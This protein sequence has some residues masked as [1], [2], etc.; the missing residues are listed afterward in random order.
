ML[1][2]HFSTIMKKAITEASKLTLGL[3]FAFFL[4]SFLPRAQ[5][6]QEIA[7]ASP[8]PAATL[9]G[10]TV[11][12]RFLNLAPSSYTHRHDS[13][14]AG[15]GIA[16]ELHALAKA[17]SLP[18]K[19]TF[20]DAVEAL[21][22]P[23]AAKALLHGAD[24]LVLGGSTWAQGSSRFMRQFFEETGSE[25]LWGAQATAYTT[26]GGSHTGGEMVVGDTLRSLMGMGASVFTLGQKY[27]VFTT[28][29]RINAPAP[30]QF[31]LLDVWFMEQFA[32]AIAVE[33]TAK[34]DPALGEKL[35]K[36][37]Q[38]TVTYYRDFPQDEAQLRGRFGDVLDLINAA[39]KPES[40][41][42]EKI[43]EQLDLPAGELQLTAPVGEMNRSASVRSRAAQR[44]TRQHRNVRGHYL[45][46]AITE[47]PPSLALPTMPDHAIHR[48]DKLQRH[49]ARVIAE[50]HDAKVAH[51]PAQ[52][53]HWPG[54]AESANLVAAVQD[55]PS[56]RS[57]RPREHPKITHRESARRCSPGRVRS[58]RRKR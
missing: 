57:A 23:G 10:R 48:A 44:F 15:L 18:I 21:D 28:D 46:A 43:S 19:I 7:P 34:S 3:A 4:G 32:K 35:A 8:P 20:H 6:Q 53:H 42:Y 38:L 12:V 55:F 37:L 11:E 54:V 33:A 31:M 27:M 25:A 49:R 24:V 52:I 14:R 29:E 58:A 5:A 51:L 39:A 40:G 1:N 9:A 56:R 22:R 50:R 41:A 47:A 36:Q 45:P 26:A 13:L 16:L 2:P 30:G 17:Q